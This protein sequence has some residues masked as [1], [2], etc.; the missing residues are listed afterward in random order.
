MSEMKLIMESWSGFIT[1]LELAK[2]SPQEIMTVG[3]LVQ[4]FKDKD[5][6]TLE[7]L[8]SK[9]GGYVAKI[10]GVSIGAVTGAAT[11]GAGIAA[12]AAAGAVAEQVVE[13]MLQASIMAF[14]DIEDGTYQPG[15]AAS[16][17]D[18]DDNLQIFMR[19][20]ETKGVDI[21]KVSKPEM[22]VFSIMKE[23]IKDAIQGDIDPN[24][25]ISALLT[26]IT[27]QSIMDVRV[28]TGK[29]SGLVKI[30]PLG[31]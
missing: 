1:E 13:Q 15:S 21:T 29:H 18:L 27:A 9:Y 11:G 3:E 24:T 7:K 20:L 19:D 6:S 31:E 23:K 14:A 25:K 28:Q 17:F 16:Y 4:Y 30:E 22:E 8:A 26:N 5:P 10:M 12:G 2:K